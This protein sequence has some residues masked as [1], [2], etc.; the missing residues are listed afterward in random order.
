MYIWKITNLSEVPGDQVFGE[1]V[2]SC[3]SPARGV[4]TAVSRDLGPFLRAKRTLEPVRVVELLRQVGEGITVAAGLGIVH[5][6]IKPQNIFQHGVTWKILDFGVSRVAANTDT[7]TSGQIVGTPAYM[8]PEQAR[9]GKVDH[10]TDL[11]ALGAVAYRALTGHGLYPSGE[12][13]D[14]LYHVV[15]GAPR[16]PSSL[17]SLSRDVDLVL[18]IALAKDPAH[19]FATATELADALEAAIADKLPEPLRERGR[20]LEA[21]GAWDRKK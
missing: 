21:E 18:A 4:R 9:G 8:A 13:A 19:R 12:V 5:R 3:Y 6:D 10:R 14:T 1:A 2:A 7:L 17:G 15:H 11:Y 16:R 20:R